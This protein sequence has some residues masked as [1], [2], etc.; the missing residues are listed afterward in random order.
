MRGEKNNGSDEIP[1][2][3]VR[4]PNGN[5]RSTPRPTPILPVRS[6]TPNYEFGSNFLQSKRSGVT[7]ESVGARERGR[8]PAAETSPYPFQPDR[9]DPAG[10]QPEHDSDLKWYYGNY[11]NE[12]LEP[13]IDTTVRCQRR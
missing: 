9:L 7:V 13:F 10:Q 5:P 2:E 4:R 11:N 6:S 12:D 3:T 1:D 8:T